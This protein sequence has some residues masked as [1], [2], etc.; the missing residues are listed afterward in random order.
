MTRSYAGKYVPFD[1]FKLYQDK[2]L[3]N[4][5]AAVFQMMLDIPLD[6]MLVSGC[7]SYAVHF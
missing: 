7:G 4:A 2:A 3:E 6:D 1:V 5:L